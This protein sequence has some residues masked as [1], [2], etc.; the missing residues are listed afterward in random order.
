MQSYNDFLSDRIKTL[1]DEISR[2]I[3]GGD[4]DVSDIADMSKEIYSYCKVIDHL[5]NGG[6]FPAPRAN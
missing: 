3:S 6:A 5:D 4:A 1:A 2:S